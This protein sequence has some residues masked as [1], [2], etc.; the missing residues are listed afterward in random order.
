MTDPSPPPAQGAT[1][2]V[3]PPDVQE[4]FGPLLEL[5]KG[6]ESMNMEER[7]YWINILP[8]MSEDQ[9]KNLEEILKNEK[10]QLA[11]IDAKYEASAKQTGSTASVAEI[12][13]GIRSKK[14]KREAIE[15]ENEKSEQQT[16]EDL[17]KQIEST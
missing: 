7:Q 15:Q 5:I 14:Q 11:A 10:D 4:K 17:L 16:E 3:I 2:L 1:G 6:S 9:I 13:E 8:V 12:E